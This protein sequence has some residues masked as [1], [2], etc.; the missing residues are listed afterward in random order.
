MIKVRILIND[1][2]YESWSFQDVE[3]NAEIRPQIPNFN[4]L[5]YRLFSNDIFHNVTFEL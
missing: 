5:E 4:P 2:N 3:S 1:R